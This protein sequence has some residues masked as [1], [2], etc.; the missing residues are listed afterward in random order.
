MTYC[1]IT[2]ESAVGQTDAF[3]NDSSLNSH[4]NFGAFINKYYTYD[5]ATTNF[6]AIFAS[7]AD[8]D[9]IRELI[10]RYLEEKAYRTYGIHE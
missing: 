4:F 1:A 3:C 2:G 8:M 6:P 9:G 5:N 10:D 7:K